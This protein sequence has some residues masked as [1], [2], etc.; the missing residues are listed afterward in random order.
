MKR[1][2]KFI[3][4]CIVTVVAIDV[5]FGAGMK[6]YVSNY[7]IPGDYET[8]DYMMKNPNED[9]YVLGSS[10]ALNSVEP[11]ILSDS[12]GISCWNGSSNA[13]SLAYC[14]VM[15]E[16]ICAGGKTKYI[17]LGM[18]HDEFARDLERINLLMPYYNSGVYTLDKY[19]NE[20]YKYNIFFL[21]SSLYRYNTIWF[22][23]LL[24][25]FVKVGK[26]G[27][28]GF[29]AKPIPSILPTM[30][31]L[32]QDKV[33]RS[34]IGQKQFMSICKL[35]KKHNVKL[36]VFFPPLYDNYEGG[37]IN[38][39]KYLEQVCL[40]NDIPVLNMSQDSTFLMHKEWFYDNEHLNENGAHV[41]SKA[42]AQWLTPHI[43]K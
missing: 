17:L 8:I 9:L 30:H 35:C 21:K 4:I 7:Q 19:L 42:M 16:K 36:L 43:K 10:I 15:T 40:D 41:F 38:G 23:I 32:P 29:V 13:Q 6:Y 14:E 28:R 26:K 22:R 5:L 24:Y 25:N 2:I 37:Y 27:E 3:A 18:R 39:Y 34:T 33:K 12:L 1:V 11:S 20:E 31:N